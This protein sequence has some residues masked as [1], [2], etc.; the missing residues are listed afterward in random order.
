MVAIPHF[1][2]LSVLMHRME[3]RGQAGLFDAELP[4]PASRL[5]KVDSAV[6]GAV[7]TAGSLLPLFTRFMREMA[8]MDSEQRDAAAVRAGQPG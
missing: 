7:L 8:A 2:M 1:A 6:F 4:E 3:K 5:P